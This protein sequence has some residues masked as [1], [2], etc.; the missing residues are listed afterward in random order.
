MR[1]LLSCLQPEL[2]RELLALGNQHL[3]WL[4]SDKRQKEVWWFSGAGSEEQLLPGKT[5]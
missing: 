1:T 5:V 4:K 2:H 3:K